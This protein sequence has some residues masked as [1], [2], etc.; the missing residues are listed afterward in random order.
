MTNKEY[1]TSLGLLVRSPKIEAMASILSAGS[2]DQLALDILR[3]RRQ[4]PF[5][6]LI[7]GVSFATWHL[8]YWLVHLFFRM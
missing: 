2:V 7:S 4:I 6:R 5:T 3:A 8:S 1:T